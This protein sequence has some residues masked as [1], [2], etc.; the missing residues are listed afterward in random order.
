MRRR[1]KYILYTISH[2]RWKANKPVAV[3]GL[4]RFDGSAQV[5]KFKQ[6]SAIWATDNMSVC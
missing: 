2:T 5:P 3:S 4:A 1:S 6:V